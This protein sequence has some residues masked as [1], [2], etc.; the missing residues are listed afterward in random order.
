MKY[1]GIMHCYLGLDICQ[2]NDD[3]FLSQGKYTV[4]I[5]REFG[6]VD[7]KSINTSMDSNLRKIHE[8]ETR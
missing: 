7:C 8:T 5:L 2:R 4:D 1:L 6:M 3:I